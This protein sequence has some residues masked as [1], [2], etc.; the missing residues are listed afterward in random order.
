MPT[1][2]YVHCV[3]WLITQRTFLKTVTKCA[4]SYGKMGGSTLVVEPPL[5]EYSRLERLFNRPVPGSEPP[6]KWEFGDMQVRKAGEAW[7]SQLYVISR[8]CHQ[9][10]LA[11]AYGRLRPEY[12][13]GT[14]LPW[15]Y[16]ESQ[17]MVPGLREFLPQFRR[18]TDDEWKSWVYDR[19][20]KYLE[21]RVALLNGSLP[22]EGLWPEYREQA[23]KVRIHGYNRAASFVRVDSRFPLISCRRIVTLSG[24]CLMFGMRPSPETVRATA[25]CEI[26]A[27]TGTIVCTQRVSV[28]LH[29]ISPFRPGIRCTLHAC[30]LIRGCTSPVITTQNM[31]KYIM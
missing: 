12:L 25:R 18:M 2:R 9:Q 6:A 20:P 17:A 21:P 5:G 23:A 26:L 29:S 22:P 4:D 1:T 14:S 15:T 16:D 27:Q 11:H 31:S 24:I 10:V 7:I 28:R 3:S 8:C 13:S 30:P 19:V